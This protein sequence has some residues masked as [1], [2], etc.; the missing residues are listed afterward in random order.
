MS[1]T[2]IVRNGV[3]EP[4]TVSKADK[5]RVMVTSEDHVVGY[6]DTV[7]EAADEVTAQLNKQR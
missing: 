1:K 3:P 7:Y 2:M 4:A 6:G 5:G